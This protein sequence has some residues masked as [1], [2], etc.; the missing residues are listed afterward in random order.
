M[1]Q[2]VLCSRWGRCKATTECPMKDII[3]DSVFDVYVLGECI[4]LKQGLVK[5]KEK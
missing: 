3:L 4:G 1:T 5:G 2:E